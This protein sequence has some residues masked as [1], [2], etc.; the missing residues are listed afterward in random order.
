MNLLLI[1]LL[2]LVWAGSYV[3]QKF[4]LAEMPVGLVLVLRYGIASLAFLLAGKLNLRQKFSNRDWALILFIG[5]LNFSGSPFFQ[6]RALQLTTAT[7]TAI[8][9]A[10][11]PLIASLIAA[12][13]IKEKIQRSTWLTFALATT[14]VIIMSGWK[15][16]VGSIHMGRLIGDLLFLTSLV[17]EAFGSTSG[18][19]LTQK[20]DPFPVIAWMIF[21][22]FLGNLAGNFQW[23]TTSSFSYVTTKSLFSV[24]FL[25]LFSS[26]FAYGGWFLF[27]QPIFGSLLA[28]LF[29][30]ERPSWETLIGGSI[31]LSTL[32]V[33]VWNHLA[34]AKNM[35]NHARKKKKIDHGKELV[36][37]IRT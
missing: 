27:L 21:F 36:A 24:L 23:L 31:V 16:S 32:F 35:K 20:H 10:F 33:W 3:G 19:H 22:G 7:D 29:L 18:R 11:E 9:V 12:L 4:A 37:E 13:F 17:C 2:Q 25:G 8:L 34:I 14:G 26:A 1:L 30:T 5:I 6:L 15:G 28:Y